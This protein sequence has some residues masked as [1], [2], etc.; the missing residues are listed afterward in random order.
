MTKVEKLKILINEFSKKEYVSV[1]DLQ[2]LAG[3]LT[4]ASTVVRGG[5]T[6][7]RRVINYLKY[8]SASRFNLTKIPDWFL[9]DLHQW[10][11]FVEN[12]NGSAKIISDIPELEIPVETDSSRSGFGARWGTQWVLGV[13]HSPFPLPDFPTS[14]WGLPP[15]IY[16][17]GFNINVLEF[18]PVLLAAKKWGRSWSGYKVRVYTDNTQV[19][20]MISTGRSSSIDCMFWLRE[21]FWIS[22]LYYFH[23]VS[24]YFPTYE[25]V[26]PDF[27]SR[28]FDPKWTSS[29]NYN[30][31]HGLCC[32]R[33]GRIKDP[34][35]RIPAQLDG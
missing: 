4:H 19:M 14:H 9:E 30:L 11:N 3:H 8:L 1:K 18:W 35:A 20:S 2:V 5:R 7:S 31:T 34:V 28:F 22:V 16:D 15:D 6:F 29:L 27:L 32:Y 13:W 23:L 26:V 25:N 10:S 17:A 12:F 24:S 21:L 33:S